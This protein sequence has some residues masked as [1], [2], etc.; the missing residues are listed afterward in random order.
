MGLTVSLFAS[1]CGNAEVAEDLSADQ[2]ERESKGSTQL[3]DD[4]RSGFSATSPTSKWSYFTFGPA[5]TGDD[6]IESTSSQGLRVVSKGCESF[7]RTAFLY[8]H[9]GS[10]NQSVFSR[11]SRWCRSR[12]V[13]GL[14]HQRIQQGISRLR[15]NHQSSGRLR[16]VGGWQYVPEPAVIRLGMQSVIPVMICGLLRLRSTR[17]MSRPSW[18]ST[19][20]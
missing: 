18:C 8:Q 6:G 13:A 19:S 20:L 16:G 12:Q 7:H 10:G 3:Y 11:T 14:Q 9:R 1:A 2:L 15:C 4:F 17:S 5:F